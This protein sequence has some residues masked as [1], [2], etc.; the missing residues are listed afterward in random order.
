MKSI[1]IRNVP[2]E[3]HRLLRVRAARNGRSLEAELR[4]VLNV[5]ARPKQA[6]GGVNATP[7][8]VSSSA[9]APLSLTERDLAIGVDEA[10]QKVRKI[11]RRD[12][13]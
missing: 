2:E 3:T 11:L 5:L 7:S 6:R 10:R 12:R 1:T 13:P 4:T 9:P 8:P